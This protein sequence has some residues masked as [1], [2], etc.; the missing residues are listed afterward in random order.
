M[1]KQLTMLRFVHPNPKI[2]AVLSWIKS[3]GISVNCH[4]SLVRELR[5]IV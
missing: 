4:T 1:P 3:F 5:A 2:C